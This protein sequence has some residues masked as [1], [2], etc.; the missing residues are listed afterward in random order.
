MSAHGLCAI[1]LDQD[2]ATGEKCRAQTLTDGVAGDQREDEIARPASLK[3]THSSC[4]AGED[5][6]V[7]LSAAELQLNAQQG[8]ATVAGD[9]VRLPAGD[10]QFRHGLPT[11]PLKLTRKGR[12][13]FPLG[14]SGRQVH[15]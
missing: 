13:G 7:Q 4:Q 8:A 6:E 3:V 15:A 2:C 14:C 5:T 1:N 10:R 12:H 11:R 9:D